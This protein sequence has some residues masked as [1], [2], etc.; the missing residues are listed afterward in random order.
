M[1]TTTIASYI[2]CAPLTVDD[3]KALLATKYFCM[4]QLGVGRNPASISALADILKAAGRAQE[5][6]DFLN[7]AN[8]YYDL[9]YDDRLSLIAETLGKDNGTGPGIS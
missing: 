6:S 1:L 4:S 3:S 8:R 7:F 2:E 9:N 5:A